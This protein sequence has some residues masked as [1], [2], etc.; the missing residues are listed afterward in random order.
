MKHVSFILLAITIFASSFAQIKITYRGDT[1]I[2]YN[3]IKTAN[4]KQQAVV[5]AHPLA[6]YVGNYIL[7]QGGNAIDAAIAT[8]FA[9]AVVYPNAG[10]LGGGGFLIAVLKNKKPYALDYRE[11]AP[12]AASRNMYL[13]SNKEAQTQKSQNGH[14]ACG[15][16]GSVAGMWESH[17]LGKL[18]WAALV[19]P[20]YKLA[21]FGFAITKSEAE[22]LN[23]HATEF[24][25]YNTR[26]TAF[27]KSQGWQEGDVLVQ[28]D[29]SNTL[30]L[31]R[32]QGRDGFYKGQ[33][34]SLIL[35]EMNRGAG[36][37]SYADLQS[38]KA[39]ERKPL[40]FT[41]YNHNII[42]MPPPSSGGVIIQQLLTICEMYKLGKTKQ[43]MAEQ[44]QLII[45]AERLAYADRAEHLGDPDFYKVPVEKIT[46][47]AYLKK[48][49]Q[50]YVAGK[51]GN[52]AQV[53]AGTISESEET[54][55]LSV[56]DKWGN[57]VSVTTTLNGS[58]GSKTVVGGAGFILNNEMDDFSIKPGVPNMYGAVG[59]EA[60]SIVP[61]KRMLSSMTPTIVLD[62]KNTPKYIIGT[63][64]GTTIPTS[65]F[66]TII[67]LLVWKQKP[68]DAVWSPKFHHQHL[69]DV[70]YMEKAY[71][72][73]IQ[74]QLKKMGYTIKLREAI[75]RTE[76]IVIDG[77][78][79]IAVADTRGND[80][81][82]GQ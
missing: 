71:D 51:A 77:K 32:D 64:G 13:D 57:A 78:K 24:K 63:P 52:S 16:P 21:K 75:G 5:S 79:I 62:A 50:N 47:K 81:A 3:F 61:Q 73:A 10:N 70:V 17:K 2:A 23:S 34:A 31:I 39:I 26:P 80:S 69:P 72:P 82:A 58:Y 28:T 65:V 30:A 9:L 66:Q 44:I 42:S 33:V 76:L 60:N 20:A 41:A 40:Q 35:D 7:Q 67:K 6:S 74:E 38:Y 36:L 1:V 29:L 49:M 45:E 18:P 54:T 48:R 11:M 59:G 8:Q 27:Y 55:H 12:L 53:K 22:N 19:E 14:L 4:Y 37:I 46:S 68:T 15:V 56:L 25:R 43:T